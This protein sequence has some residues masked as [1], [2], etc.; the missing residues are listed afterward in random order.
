MNKWKDI[1]RIPFSERQKIKIITNYNLIDKADGSIVNK[2]R[3][4]KVIV[5]QEEVNQEL[6]ITLQELFG[7]DIEAE[8][9]RPS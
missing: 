6:N 1:G 8:Y 5:N 4:E 3:N 9:V 2:L 7:D